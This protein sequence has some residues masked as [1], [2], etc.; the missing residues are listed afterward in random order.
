VGAGR[1]SIYHYNTPT[2]IDRLLSALP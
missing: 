1:A 2:E